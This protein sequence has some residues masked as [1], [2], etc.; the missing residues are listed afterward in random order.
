MAICRNVAGSADLGFLQI[1]VP[2]K[3]PFASGIC[4]E[5]NASIIINTLIIPADVDG[6]IAVLDDVDIAALLFL[7]DGGGGG[8]FAAGRRSRPRS[9]L[10]VSLDV[11]EICVLMS[12]LVR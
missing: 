11:E 5:V 7:E 6:M 2:L 8:I 4:L 1:R 10:A 9:L 12:N 3:K